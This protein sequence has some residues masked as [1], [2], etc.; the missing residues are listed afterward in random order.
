MAALK[1]SDDEIRWLL[2][3]AF[4][5]HAVD[6]TIAKF[7]VK[8]TRRM[9]NEYFKQNP[10]VKAQWDQALLDAVPFLENDLLTCHTRLDFKDA[11][12]YSNNVLRVLAARKPEKYGNKVDINLNQ[13]ISIR[14]NLEKSSERLSNLLKEVGPMLIPSIEEKK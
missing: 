13:T 11:Q 7:G 2:D 6:K 9:L 10:E 12:V 14:S 5:S 8:W 4:Y 1:L 3:D